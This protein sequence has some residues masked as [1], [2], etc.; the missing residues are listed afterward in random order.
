ME[1]INYKMKTKIQ[2]CEKCEEE[3]LHNIR[4]IE[5]TNSRGSYIRRIVTKCRQCGK[6]EIINRKNGNTIIPGKNTLKEVS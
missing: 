2:F 1:W 6:R 3:T 4:K 5:S